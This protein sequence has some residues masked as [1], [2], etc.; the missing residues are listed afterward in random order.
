MKMETS[1]LRNF[2]INTLSSIVSMI[3]HCLMVNLIHEYELF[4]TLYG[5][6]G[7]ISTARP[8]ASMPGPS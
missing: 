7:L 5:K 6:G 8:A 3:Y 2:S 1:I 4:F